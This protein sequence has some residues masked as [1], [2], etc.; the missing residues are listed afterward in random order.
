[1]TDQTPVDHNSEIVF[2]TDAENCNPNGNPK[3]NNRPRIDP[4][5]QKCM[6][7]DVRLKRY[8]REQLLDDGHKVF[9]KKGGDGESKSRA[10]LALDTLED[11]ETADDFD[12]IND[13]RDEF[14]NEAVDVRYFGGAMTFNADSDTDVYQEVKSRFPSE[15]KGAVQ[16]LPT[17]SL[18]E[19]EENTESDALS[20]VISTNEG[21]STGG[22]LLDDHRIKYGVFPFY[23]RVDAHSA[24][25]VNLSEADVKRLD[26][27]CW[28]AIKSQADS[29]SK[30][31]QQPRIYV[32]VEYSTEGYFHGDVHHSFEIDSEHS[33][34][35]AELRSVKDVALDVSGFLDLL[36]Q[37]REHIE[38]V[39]ITGDSSLTITDGTETL[40]VA[41]DLPEIVR[42]Q[43]VSVHDIDVYTEYQETVADQQD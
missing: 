41:G 8:L 2:I 27:L 30:L 12:K 37:E 9:V 18:N 25:D 5:T 24:D 17:W 11:V 28:R 31:G 22:Y 4:V 1:M 29:R 16:F 15:F 10:A 35:D 34:S 36:E 14:L 38:C 13:I 32:R 43:G 33:S 21:K 42:E 7:T 39:H 26:T 6:I 19:V 40:G 3:D 20:S 23:G